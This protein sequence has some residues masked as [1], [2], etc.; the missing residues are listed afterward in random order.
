MY[1]ELDGKVALV[2]GAARRAGLGAA[3]VRRLAAEGA[4]VVIHDI[5]RANDAPAPAGALGLA[6][7]LEEFAAELW[8]AGASVATVTGDM[9]VEA[10][11]E[12]MV[13]RAVEAFGR[14]DVLVNN[15]G[16]GYLFA[17]LLEMSQE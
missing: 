1:P 16:V 5:G 10:D 4:R 14:L 8:A 11:V 9:L 3:I 13:A 7:E 17:P 2:T 15:A 6:E 12:R